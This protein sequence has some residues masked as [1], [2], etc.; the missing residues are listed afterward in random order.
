[1]PLSLQYICVRIYCC[2][3]NP[4]SSCSIPCLLLLLLRCYCRCNNC[5]PLNSSKVHVYWLTGSPQTLSLPLLANCTAAPNF[6]TSLVVYLLAPSSVWQWR[7]HNVSINRT[8][9][10]ALRHILYFFALHNSICFAVLSFVHTPHSDHAGRNGRRRQTRR[11]KERTIVVQYQRS[12]PLTLP[13][14]L[15]F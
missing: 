11:S 2:R 15:Q 14:P 5:C 3:F 6:G 8:K 7:K 12:M 4:L 13:Y 9:R 10:Q 1:M